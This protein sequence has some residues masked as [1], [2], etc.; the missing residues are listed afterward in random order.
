MAD[1]LEHYGDIKSGGKQMLMPDLCSRTYTAEVLRTKG[2]AEL[3]AD[4][5]G[6][7]TT[8]HRPQEQVNG[9]SIDPIVI[10][11]SFIASQ[12]RF[13]RPNRAEEAAT[14][15]EVGVLP[16]TKNIRGKQHYLYDL[17]LARCGLDVMV[18]VPYHALA[19]IFYSQVD[20]ALA[21]K[22]VVYEKLDIRKLVIR[23][24]KSGVANIPS[25]E[26]HH[27]LEIGLTRCQLAYSDPKGRSRDL[28]VVSLSGGHLGTTDVYQYVVEPVINP[29][30][31]IFE[32]TPVLMGFAL[33]ADG[34]KKTSATTDRHGNFKLWVGPGATRVERLFS[35]LDGIGA[36]EGIISTTANVP[37]LQSKTIEGIE[38]G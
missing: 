36:I 25:S 31:S 38:E 22:R 13:H 21:G 12:V 29:K 33:F 26:S 6:R 15:E 23:L 27:K 11:H 1:S 2:N 8:D 34:I 20:R 37:I 18:A 14:E 35:L 7:L 32:V 17:L 24:G 19:L 16:R 5:I 30:A 9:P 4:I 28:Q 10:T 3:V